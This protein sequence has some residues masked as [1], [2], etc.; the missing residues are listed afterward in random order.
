MM[1]DMMDQSYIR[2]G[3]PCWYLN[4][5]R[6]MA[7][8]NDGYMMTISIYKLL[9]KYFRHT[10]YYFKIVELFQDV[11]LNFLNNIYFEGK[12]IFPCVCELK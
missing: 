3:K 11:S 12:F 7:A 9:K 8:I 4:D 10:P 2:R 6:G 5:N 1:D